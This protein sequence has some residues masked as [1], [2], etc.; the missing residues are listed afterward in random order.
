[1]AKASVIRKSWSEFR[2]TGL[3]LMVNQFLHIFGWA[4]VLEI[5]QDTE[6]V[7]ACYPARVTFRGFDEEDV[8]DAYKGVSAYLKDNIDE[9]N[10]EAQS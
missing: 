6:E 3:F 10:E 7:T 4:I 5:N 1:M 2:K 9:I 8:T